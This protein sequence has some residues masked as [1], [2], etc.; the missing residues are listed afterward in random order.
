[1]AKMK[2]LISL[3]NLLNNNRL[4]TFSKIKKHCGISRSTAYRYLNA[5][6]EANVPVFY[7]EKLK[8]YRLTK[9]IMFRIGD[10]DLNDCVLVICGLRLLSEHVNRYYQETLEALIKKL[11]CR[12]CDFLDD[13]CKYIDRE[14]DSAAKSRDY[15]AELNSILIALAVRHKRRLIVLT[16]DGNNGHKYSRVDSPIIRFQREWKVASSEPSANAQELP[17]KSI[18]KVDVH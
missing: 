13:L 5:L 16:G 18:L 15:S 3:V 2:R 9:E 8:G 1:M 4:V 11:S 17:I 7:D 6:S 12:N 14:L 10:L